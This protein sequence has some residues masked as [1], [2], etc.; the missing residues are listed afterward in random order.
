MKFAMNADFARP[1]AAYELDGILYLPHNSK[2][3][4]YVSPGYRYHHRN[5]HTA[6]ELTRAGAR[7]VME[8]L[9]VGSDLPSWVLESRT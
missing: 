8:H 9:R 3:G 5:E 7:R 1:T 6:A 2:V 4:V